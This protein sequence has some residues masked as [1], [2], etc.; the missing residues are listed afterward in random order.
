MEGRLTEGS[1]YLECMD[2]NLCYNATT[3]FDV[4]Q[5]LFKWTFVWLYMVFN[6]SYQV[7]FL[8]FSCKVNLSEISLN[9]TSGE[10]VPDESLSGV[11]LVLYLQ[12]LYGIEG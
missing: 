5:T 9:I 2:L 3:T 10:I 6:H 8:Q 4:F 7:S 1:P 12:F 11:R